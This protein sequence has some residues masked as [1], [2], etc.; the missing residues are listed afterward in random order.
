MVG[1]AAQHVALDRDGRNKLLL[2]DAE[3]GRD[4]G[5]A[6]IAAKGQCQAQ[7]LDQ[8]AQ[9][10]RRA[11]TADRKP[12]AARMQALDRGN[13]AR[14]QHLA[15]GDEGTV[16]IGDD[17][18]DFCHRRAVPPGA[19]TSMPPCEAT[20]TAELR[21]TK[22]PFSTTPTI[23][24]IRRSVSAGS[25]I[26]ANRQSRMK[27]PPSVTKGSPEPARRNSGR[28]SSFSSNAP[29]ASQ[30]NCATSTGS[31]PVVP[32]RSTSLSS[33]TMTMNLRLPAV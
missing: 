22:S 29:V 23:A 11:A 10:A 18:R 2:D 30:P 14:C 8:H 27:L 12:D 33:S 19:R 20:M 6:I 28:A 5:A 13:R 7:R 32:S 21:P 26:E 1:S 16:D 3:I 25:S 15:A 31:A 4:D 9:H 24:L 17:Q